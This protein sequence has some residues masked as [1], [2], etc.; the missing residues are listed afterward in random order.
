MK[1]L[2]R[3]I[4]VFSLVLFLFFLS[5]P[6]LAQTPPPNLLFEHEGAIQ[7]PSANFEKLSNAGWQNIAIDSLTSLT[8][9]PRFDAQ[10]NLLGFN[11]DGAFSTTNQLIASLYQPPASGIQYLA[12][13]KDNFLGKPA[14]AQGVGF[15][16]LTPILPVW[17]AFRNV[18]YILSSLIFIIIGIMI[19]LRVKL[20]PQA[21]VNIQNAVP[22]LITTLILVTFSYAIAGLLIDLM[23]LIQAFSLVVLFQA[24]GKNLNEN[25]FGAGLNFTNPYTFSTLSQ[26]GLGEIFNLT[27]KAVPLTALA[28]ITGILGAIVGGVF[29]LPIFGVGAPVGAILGFGIGAII[30][31]L[32]IAILILI[33][34]I[35][36]FFGLVKCYVQVILKIVTAP[37]EI[38]LGAIPGFKGGGFSSW[39][40]GLIANLAVFPISV[41]FLVLANIIIQLGSGGRLWQPTLLNGSLLSGITNAA[42]LTGG[43]LATVA[44]GLATLMIM[45]KLPTLI[46]Q[47]IFAIKPSPWEQAINLGKG[48]ELLM[49]TGRQFAHDQ[50]RSRYDSQEAVKAG[51]ADPKAKVGKWV[52]Q[53][54]ELIGIAK[55]R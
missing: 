5:R 2:F 43:G 14:Y 42:T 30:I 38:G 40:Y 45:S 12:E 4:F 15:V 23:N 37:L 21:V 1:S 11:Q 36:F 24:T 44:I 9:R 29:S 27:Y 33:W 10:G 54:M 7:D 34:L 22:G 25:L 19:M 28:P 53:G 31:T 32:I 49:A 41:L 51:S 3:R 6:S 20:S 16:G 18:V 26:P 47:A 50:L 52:A 35:S 46:P 39:I 55:P 8:G 17:R 48:G 13:L